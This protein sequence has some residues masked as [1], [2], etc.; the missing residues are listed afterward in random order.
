MKRTKN[1]A[2]LGATILA[3]GACTT[4]QDATVGFVETSYDAQLTGAAV[5]GTGDPDGSATAQITITDNTDAVCYNV[6]NVRGIGAA[7]DAHI[8]RGRA[9][10][11]GPVIAPLQRA[12]GA[13][14]NGCIESS[15]LTAEMLR[16]DPGMFYVQIH[17]AEYPAGA[18]RGQLQYD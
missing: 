14:W 6:W 15:Q 17:T 4:A 13:G 5:A 18:I 1:S 2:A 16:A 8:H 9:G 7:G 12:D 11:N 10:E 3:L